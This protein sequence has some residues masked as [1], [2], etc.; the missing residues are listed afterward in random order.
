MAMALPQRKRFDYVLRTDQPS[1]AG[2]KLELD[3]CSRETVEFIRDCKKGA[4]L[5]VCQA[6]HTLLAVQ[7]AEE[8]PGRKPS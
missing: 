3:R 4:D 8:S 2:L 7:V 1:A 5:F 6:K